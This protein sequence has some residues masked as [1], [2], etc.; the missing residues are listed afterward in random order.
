MTP[1]LKGFDPENLTAGEL[2]AALKVHGDLIL[3]IP[4][5][6]V[7]NIKSRLSQYKTRYAA[8]DKN[9]RLGYTI[10]RGSARKVNSTEVIDLQVNLKGQ[11]VLPIYDLRKPEEY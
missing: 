7:D 8:N 9:R 11:E 1:E 4:A 3:T 5:D 6:Q 2:Y 10:L